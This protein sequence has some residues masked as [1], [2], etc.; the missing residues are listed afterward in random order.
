MLFL[1]SMTVN[2]MSVC[3]GFC[4]PVKTACQCKNVASFFTPNALPY[5]IQLDELWMIT[6]TEG[7]N[8]ASP[9]TFA[10]GFNPNSSVD[11]QGK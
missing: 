5:Y 6:E 3:E 7:L 2:S 11:A 8:F 10:R 4:W 1:T 9:L